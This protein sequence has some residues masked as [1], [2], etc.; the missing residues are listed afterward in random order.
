MHR[1]QI[2]LEECQHEALRTLA[3]RSGRSVSHLLREAVDLLL[4]T[5]RGTAPSLDNVSGMVSDATFCGEDH[6]LHLY[7]TRKKKR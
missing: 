3:A 5:R 7:G 1:T 4:K 6:D 2:L